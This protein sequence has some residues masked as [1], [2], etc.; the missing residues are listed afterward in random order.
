[1]KGMTVVVTP[2]DY[3]KL[4]FVQ[5]VFNILSLHISQI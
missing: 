2:D 5:L 4:M 3:K 1:M